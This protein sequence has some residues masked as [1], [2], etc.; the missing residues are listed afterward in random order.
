[1]WS[2]DGGE[3]DPE[4]VELSKKYSWEYVAKRKDFYIFR[5]FDPSARELNTD[6]EVQALALNAVKKRQRN[7][8]FSSVFF[9]LIY[10]VLLTRGC[11][12]L[13]TISMGTWWMALMLLLAALMIVDN[14]RALIH[15]KKVQKSLEY[16]GYHNPKFDWRKNAVPYF[17]RKIIKTVIA[18]LLIFTFLRSWGIS[19]TNEK[20]IPIEEYNGTVPF[21]TIQDFAG[22]YSSE[23]TMTMMGLNMGFNTIE[24]KSDWVAPRYIEYNEHAT[25]KKSDVR[26]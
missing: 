22:E 1:M 3:P 20:K 21:A 15:L 8:L 25:V 16:S 10:P 26:L 6:P 13:T 2:D 4:L 18:V 7:T 14:V 19:V 24:E 12:L 9:L 17:I 23:Y 5:S 11:L